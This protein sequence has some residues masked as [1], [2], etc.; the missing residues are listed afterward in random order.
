MGLW[1]AFLDLVYL[2]VLW[3]RFEILRCAQDDGGLNLPWPLFAKERM[4]FWVVFLF[5]VYL[6]VLRL[7]FEILRCA[8]DDGGLNLPWPSLLKREMSF[9]V[10]FL[11]PGL[12]NMN[13]SKLTRTIGIVL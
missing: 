7:R 6:E 13:M 10:V 12:F 3:L 1:V 5:L 2:E 4:S 9:W 8:Q 11:C